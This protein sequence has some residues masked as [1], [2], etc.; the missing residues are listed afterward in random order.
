[1]NTPLSLT[2]VEGLLFFL[3]AAGGGML[4]FWLSNVLSRR[5]GMVLPW[6]TLLVN[7]SG[8]VAL[9]FLAASLARAEQAELLWLVL[10]IG[11]FG[12][13]TTVS[14][15][16]LQTLSLWQ[17]GQWQ[18]ALINVLLTLSLGLCSAALGFYWG[19]G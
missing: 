17:A 18:G 15:F 11:F 16:S 19:H 13:Y 1:M 2:A 14:S 10:G 8:A 4:R 12:A 7:C 3:A 5:L 9:G 6:G